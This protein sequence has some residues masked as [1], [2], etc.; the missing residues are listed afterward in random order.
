MRLAGENMNRIKKIRTFSLIFV[1]AFSFFLIPL[2]LNL[3][4]TNYKH[5]VEQSNFI[6]SSAETVYNQEWLN[7]NDFSSQDEWFYNQGALGDNS[8]TDANISGGSA[9][10]IVVGEDSSFSLTAGKANSSSWYGWG[11]Y[12]NGDFLQ[13]DVVEIN[14]TGCYVYHFL[15]ESEGPNSQGQ[16]HNFPS[17]HFRKNISLLDD[18]TDYEITAASLEVFFNASVDSN[19]DVYGDPVGQPIDPDDGIFDSATFY[20]EIT[21]L[22]L[23]FPFRV[24]ENKTSSLGRDSPPSLSI[25]DRELNYVS[26]SDLI[27]ALNLALEKD[28]NHSDFTIIMGIDIYCED[29]DFPDYD[30]WNYLIFKSFNLTFNYERKVDQF[31]SISWNQKGNAISG[32]NIHVSDANLKFRYMIDQDWPASL[33]PFSEIRIIINNNLYPETVQLSSA[34]TLWQDAKAGGFDVT[35]LILKDANISVSLQVFIANTFSLSEN[36]TISLDD[37]FLNITYVE[38]FADYGTE[39]QLFLETINKT[40]DPFIQVPLGNTVNIT[41]KYLDNETGAHISGANVQLSGKVS[42]QLNENSTL[43]HYSRITNSTDLGIGIW[44]LTVIAQ[45]ANYETQ[46]IP[47]FIDVVER[48]TDLQLHVNDVPKT[49]NNTVK[50]KYDMVMNITIFYRDNLTNQ[51]LSGANVTI[52]NFGDLTEN[53][54]QYNYSLNS[55]ALNLGFNVLTIN[56]H[57][58]NYTSQL[59]Q[60]YVEVFER[61][62]EFELYVNEDQKANNDIIQIEVNQILNLTV[63]YRDDITKVHLSGAE[64]TLLTVGNFIEIGTQYNYTLNSNDL[65]LGFNVLSIF[66]QLDNYE[67]QSIQIYI[68]VYNIATELQLLV[69][70]IPTDALEIIQVEV[71]QFVNLTVF[72]RDNV[73]KLHISGAIVSLGWD[74]FTETGSQYYYNLDTNDLDQGITIVTIVA[75]FNNYQSQTIQIY[76]EVVERATE[77]EVHIDSSQRTEAETILADVNQILNITVFYRDNISKLHL[78]GATVTILGGN[79]S[80]ISNQYNYSLNTN[81]LEQGISILTVFA[82]LNNFHPQT[83]QFYIKVTERASQVQLFLDLED[84]TTDPVVELP[85]GSNL[86]ITIKYTDNQTGLHINGG[87]VQLTADNFSEDLNEFPILGQYTL[88]LDTSTIKIGVNL[89]TILVHANNFQLKTINLRITV[90]KISTLINSTSGGSYV[91]LLTGD[92][93]LLSVILKDLDF[94]GNITNAIVTYKWA[95]G[96]GTLLDN[97]HDGVYESLLVNVPLGTYTITITASAGD[98]YNFLNYKITLNVV[99]ESLPDYTLLFMALAGAFV[100]LIVGLTLYQTHFKYPPLVRKIRKIKKKISK[101]KNIKPIGTLSRELLVAKN[102]QDKIIVSEYEPTQIEK[103]KK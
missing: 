35:N 89:F 10:Y 98:N 82:Y 59:I 92:S 19:V 94:G 27:T 103:K 56:A 55:N 90:N 72:Y 42:G 43:E 21:D 91:S 64:A 20:I 23:S 37:V 11:N 29:N 68:D 45:K 63:F 76:F 57:S 77:I 84:K 2:S 75:Q 60:L 25:P 80:E 102:L 69:D 66:T 99:S 52:T 33:S 46:I 36:I 5:P 7:N 71:N 65:S 31:S 70:Y 49:T 100:A 85:I 4:N 12:S 81:S 9:N 96:N 79:F 28:P 1:I 87:N 24:A 16:T 38:I 74:N 8:T 95:Y 48:P 50:I 78:S 73:T 51:H 13:P 18:M 22:G 93:V 30:L 61:A 44:S 41:I 39:S 6:H 32:S 26:E 97:D 47:F 62:T 34:T 40:V 67:S 88:I 17:V 15:D 53:N 83:F 58:E 101:D 54:E 14:E 3:S 86:N